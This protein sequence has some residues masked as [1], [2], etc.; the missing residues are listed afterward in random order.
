[1]GNR[2]HS[3]GSLVLPAF[4]PRY[5][6][7]PSVSGDHAIHETVLTRIPLCKP[8]FDLKLLRNAMNEFHLVHNSLRIF[9]LIIAS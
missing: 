8:G 7:L 4:A 6:P 3:K 1:M 2:T 9:D 5:L